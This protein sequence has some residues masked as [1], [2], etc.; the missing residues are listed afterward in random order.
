MRPRLLVPCAAAVAALAAAPPPASAATVECAPR[1]GVQVTYARRAGA[2]R[3]TCDSAFRV[4]FKG[5]LNRRTPAGWT[6]RQPAAARW[7]V[8]ETCT[9]RRRGRA[10]VTANLLELR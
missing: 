5:I 6:C 7:P 3:V 10:V 2:P 9:L 8:V 1:E 4:L